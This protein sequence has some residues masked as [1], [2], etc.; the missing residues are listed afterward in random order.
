MQQRQNMFLIQHDTSQ[1]T[2]EV[3]RSVLD[4]MP[5]DWKAVPLV[6]CL[7]EDLD[8]A[9]ALPHWTMFNAGE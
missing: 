7:G 9:Y 3:L 5:A 1:T 2:L 6:E 8:Q 4:E